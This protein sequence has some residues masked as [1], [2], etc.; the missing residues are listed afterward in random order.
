MEV[1]EKAFKI[2]Q[3]RLEVNV[4]Y[5]SKYEDLVH[6]YNK[7]T[8]TLIEENNSLKRQIRDLKSS[9]EHKEHLL[10]ENQIMNIAMS[11]ED[12]LMHESVKK[13]F[14]GIYGG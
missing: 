2:L 1:N 12:N 11:E 14:K 7:E 6:E 9:I 8:E 3:A 5:R 4:M 13:Q 10:L